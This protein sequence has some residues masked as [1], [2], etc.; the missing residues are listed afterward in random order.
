M[1]NTKKEH[2]HN[3]DVTVI[4]VNYNTCQL[5]KECIESIYKN[6]KGI[7]FEIIVSDN[8]STDGSINMVKKE[9]PNVYLV[10]NGNNLGF[11]AANNVALKNAHGKYIFYLNS[12]TRLLNN[13]IEKFFDYMESAEDKDKIG[14]V[15]CMLMDENMKY[16][17][18]YVKYPT[19]LSLLAALIHVT[20]FPGF[21]RA[22]GQTEVGTIIKLTDSYIT[23][24][25]FF[26]R[27][28][29][30]AMF[31]E[32][33]FMYSEETDLQYN[34]F[35]LK[36]KYNVILSEPKIVH[37]GGASTGSNTKVHNKYFNKKSNVIMWISI[38]KYL[39]KNFPQNRVV[40]S[41]IR[42]YLKV[43]LRLSK[44]TEQRKYIEEINMI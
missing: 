38:L 31:D 36:G 40:F 11:G 7:T 9:F 1:F 32:R 19:P 17:Q 34:H 30:D 6:T 24:A 27:N 5:T 15:G 44:V 43:C 26:L 25:A 3:V 2:E 33:Y 22:S 37:Y 41:L 20:V 12:D 23:G 42:Q 28:N 16:T 35:Y 10:E 39:R 21:R 8:G 29:S 14:C 13:A 4:I 18:S